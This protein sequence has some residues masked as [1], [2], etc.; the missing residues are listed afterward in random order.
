MFVLHAITTGQRRVKFHCNK[1]NANEVILED[2]HTA[3]N[4]VNISQ[5]SGNVWATSTNLRR[6][7]YEV[8]FVTTRLYLLH[9]WQ[10]C[11]HALTTIHFRSS[12]MEAT[13]IA[14]DT[15]KAFFTMFWN[16]VQTEMPNQ[17]W[18]N[19]LGAET[20]LQ[21]PGERGSQIVYDIWG[22]PTVVRLSTTALGLNG[23]FFQLP[24]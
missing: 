24:N 6:A 15:M 19:Y 22:K 9:C 4:I 23:F 2:V 20:G 18:V 1:V 11:N 21:L 7:R 16:C 12:L 3:K 14:K 13:E 10:L 8:I 5:P 17:R